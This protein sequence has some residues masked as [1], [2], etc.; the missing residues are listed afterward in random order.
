M[1][2]PFQVLIIA[3]RKTNKG[4]E[5]LVLERADMRVCQWISG[6]GEDDETPLITAI[7]ETHEEIGVKATKFIKLDTITSIPAVYFENHANWGENVVVIPEYSFGLEITDEKINL[8][9]EHIQ[10]KWEKYIEAKKI[11][12]WDSNITALYELNERLNKGLVNIID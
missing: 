4:Y 8:S 11:L 3:F 1:R 2:A 9:S 6:G 10:Y 12:K 5:F 7:R